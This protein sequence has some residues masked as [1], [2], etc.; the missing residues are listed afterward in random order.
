MNIKE[1]YEHLGNHAYVD[2]SFNKRSFVYGSGIVIIVNNEV[3]HEQSLS[4]N[5]P[6]LSKQRNVAGEMRAA[7]AAMKF[8]INNYMTSL[9]IHYD[10]LGIEKWVTG[11]WKRN[12][13]Y[14]ECYHEF[15]NK[16]IKDHNISVYFRKVKAHSNDRFN[17]RA[18]ELA[19]KG[20]LL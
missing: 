2:G 3:V 13:D 12:N 20:A 4:G 6:I 18:D 5:D 19:K 17:D 16:M 15:M 8:A 9:V 10:Y 14:T 7:M 1:E 11:E